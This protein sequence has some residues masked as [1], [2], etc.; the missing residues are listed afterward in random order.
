[1]LN[2]LLRLLSIILIGL[3]SAVLGWLIGAWVG[4]NFAEQV[5]FN[6]VRGYEATGQIGSILGTLIGLLSSSWLLF[7]RKTVSMSR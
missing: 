1:M 4:G 3:V 5:V 7:R 6:G 2:T